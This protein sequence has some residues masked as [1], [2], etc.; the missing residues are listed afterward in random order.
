MALQPGLHSCGSV[1]AEIVRDH[2]D[3]API[4]LM[5]RQDLLE[6]MAEPDLVLVRPRPPDQ[7]AG[8]VMHGPK[9]ILFGVFARRIDLQ[10]L[11]AAHCGVIPRTNWRCR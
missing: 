9:D 7:G 5:Q 2:H 10:L 6:Q 8:P 3:A 4:Q 1:N 11:S